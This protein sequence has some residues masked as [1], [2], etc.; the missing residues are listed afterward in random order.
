MVAEE[1]TE[2]LPFSSYEPTFEPFD[3]PTLEDQDFF[4]G[5]SGFF[6]FD[7]QC[8]LNGNQQQQSPCLSDNS[9]E[10]NDSACGSPLGPDYT[11]PES[12]GVQD[13]DIS[14]VVPLW[15]LPPVAHC[16]LP[17]PSPASPA[18]PPQPALQQA[19]SRIPCHVGAVVKKTDDKARQ[20][21][22]RNTEAAR[23][24]RGRNKKRVDELETLVGRL[25]HE[26]QN[27]RL[28]MGENSNN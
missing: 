8:N 16:P 15:D 28:K 4:S 20:R 27:L 10:L 1:V 14:P 19:G 26:N 12:V 24:S 9:T 6:D 22:M 18:S 13:I 23:R 3:K 7:L 2:F 17:P 5:F 25:M 21:R 11:P